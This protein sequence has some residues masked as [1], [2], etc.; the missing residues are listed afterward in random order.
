MLRGVL[1]AIVQDRLLVLFGGFFY[2]VSVVRSRESLGRAMGGVF[3]GEYLVVYGGRGLL[4]ILV[5][6]I[7]YVCFASGAWNTSVFST[8]PIC[9]ICGIRNAFVVFILG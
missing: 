4:A 8:S 1:Y 7:Y 5:S 9:T 6:S 2:F 3:S